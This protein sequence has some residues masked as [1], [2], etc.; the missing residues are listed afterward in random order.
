MAL[1]FPEKQLPWCCSMP[2]LV[3]LGPFM[4]AVNKCVLAI[5]A[6]RRVEAGNENSDLERHLDHFVCSSV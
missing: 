4:L 1:N 2:W 3:T 5:L 6:I